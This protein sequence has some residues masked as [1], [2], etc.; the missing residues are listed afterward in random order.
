M[1]NQ[2]SKIGASRRGLVPEA[3]LC[4]NRPGGG[5]R[6]GPLYVH[7]DFFE[8]GL[9]CPIPGGHQIVERLLN[10]ADYNGNR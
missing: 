7:S 6:P 10:L 3:E 8:S 9:V 5:D 2:E 4:S 1:S